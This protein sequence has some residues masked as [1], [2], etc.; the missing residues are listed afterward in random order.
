MDEEGRPLVAGRPPGQEL[1][2]QSLK[3][4]AL[5]QALCPRAGSEVRETLRPGFDMAAVFQALSTMEIPVPAAF[6]SSDQRLRLHHPGGVGDIL[7]DADGGSWL[8]GNI[9]TLAPEAIAV[10]VI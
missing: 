1:V 4:M 9:S 3:V 10:A 2:D 8:R 7:T 5:D 6:A